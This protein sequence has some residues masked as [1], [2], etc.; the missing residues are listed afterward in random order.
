V[1][2]ADRRAVL[3]HLNTALLTLLNSGDLDRLL[4]RQFAP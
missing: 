3:Y 4:E 2:D 1:V